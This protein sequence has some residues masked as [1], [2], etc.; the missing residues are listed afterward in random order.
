MKYKI[1]ILGAESTGK[2]TLARQLAEH[3]SG[4]YVAEYARQYVE[5]LLRPY[6][7]QDVEA[8][9]RKQI[10]QLT[11]EYDADYVFFD[12]ELIVTKVWFEDKYDIVPPFLTEAM[13]IFKPDFC[14]LCM[15]DLQ[16]VAD[17]VRE[18]GDRREELTR[19]YKN[20]LQHYQI[21]F[22]CISG[23]NVTRLHNAIEAI[24][25]RTKR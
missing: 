3:Y 11:T 15:P 4:I 18:N 20:E 6:I 7:F 21:P 8:I 9:A 19:W 10:E 1:G 23:T 16:F 5:Q 25:A 22:A 14:L 17:P 12:T 13:N 2:S 24:D